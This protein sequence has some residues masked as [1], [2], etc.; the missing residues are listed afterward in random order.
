MLVVLVVPIASLLV[1]GTTRDRRRWL[2]EYAARDLRSVASSSAGTDAADATLA[3]LVRAALSDLPPEFSRRIENVAVVIED[4][5]PADK[6]W[7]ACYFGV[8]PTRQ[9]EWGWMFPHK[10]T[11]FRG[12]L[13]RHYGHDPVLLDQEVRHVVRH[14]LAHYFGISDQQLVDMGRY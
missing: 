2:R 11:I 4:E 12:P 10:I 14:E 5:P 6:P 13:E 8:P 9:K 7:L 3:G 1:V